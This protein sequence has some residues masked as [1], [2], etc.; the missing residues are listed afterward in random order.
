MMY[1]TV[2]TDMSCNLGGKIKESSMTQFVLKSSICKVYQQPQASN[3][4][5][6]SCN[7]RGKQI[8]DTLHSIDQELFKLFG[9]ELMKLMPKHVVLIYG[10]NNMY[11]SIRIVKTIKSCSLTT[12]SVLISLNVSSVVVHIL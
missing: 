1:E 2:C 6:S 12:C 5:L 7:Q 10:K 4:M 3:H 8:D 11:I 9:T